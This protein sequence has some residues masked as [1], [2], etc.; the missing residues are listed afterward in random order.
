MCDNKTDMCMCVYTRLYLR[1]KLVGGHKETGKRVLFLRRE[2]QENVCF[3]F[4]A[5][6]GFLKIKCFL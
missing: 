6:F 3:P 1:R 4:F 2:V 5:H